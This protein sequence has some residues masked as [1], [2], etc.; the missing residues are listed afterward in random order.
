MTAT[1]ELCVPIRLNAIA[2]AIAETIPYTIRRLVMLPFLSHLTVRRLAAAG[3]RHVH[4]AKADNNHDAAHHRMV[5]C[6]CTDG[7]GEAGN[8]SKT[9]FCTHAHGFHL[10]YEGSTSSARF[11]SGS[12]VG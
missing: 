8:G 10:L 3:A 6:K 2:K 7:D 9:C 5:L 12:I 1:V 4:E 11:P